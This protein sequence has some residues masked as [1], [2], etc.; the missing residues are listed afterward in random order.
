MGRRPKVPR[1]A[2]KKFAI[3][4]EGL[5]SGKVFEICRKQ[6]LV[7][8]CS[9]AGKTRWRK[10]PW[11]RWGKKRSRAGRRRASQTHQATGAF[12]LGQ[13]RGVQQSWWPGHEHQ[14]VVSVL[15]AE[16]PCVAGRPQPR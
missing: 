7:R 3:F 13:P 2:E 16:T 5:K 10:V 4:M 1:S 15:P 12:P 11:L 14:P 6:R 9:I 8:R